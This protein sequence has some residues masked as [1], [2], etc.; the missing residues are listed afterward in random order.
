MC[1]ADLR[2]LLWAGLPCMVHYVL[3]EAEQVKAV[4]HNGEGVKVVRRNGKGPKV[5]PVHIVRQCLES[6]QSRAQA[7]GLGDDIRQ[8]F[9]YYNATSTQARYHGY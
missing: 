5:E 3:Q 8:L 1:G 6:V 7:K 2:H 4:L 9:N